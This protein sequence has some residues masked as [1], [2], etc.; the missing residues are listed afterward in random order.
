MTNWNLEKHFTGAVYELSQHN[1]NAMI[2]D[3]ELLKIKN[4]MLKGKRDMLKIK[5][6]EL[7]DKVEEALATIRCSRTVQTEGGE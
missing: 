4:F 1:M 2:A 6:E 3:I 7:D 5:V